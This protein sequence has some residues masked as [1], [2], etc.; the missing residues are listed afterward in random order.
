MVI[1]Y[2]NTM[3]IIN[4]LLTVGK[5]KVDLPSNAVTIFGDMDIP[6]Q[7]RCRATKEAILTV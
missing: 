4:I 5:N 6:L 3:Y 2:R 1:K 7:F